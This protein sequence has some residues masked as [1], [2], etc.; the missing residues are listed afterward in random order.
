MIIMAEMSSVLPTARER[1]RERERERASE[2]VREN[3]N[4]KKKNDNVTCRN[5]IHTWKK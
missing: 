5:I 2:R 1:E 4:Y 3:L